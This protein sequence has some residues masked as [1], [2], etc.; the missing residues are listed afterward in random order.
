VLDKLPIDIMCLIVASFDHLHCDI[1][2]LG[3]TC[4]TLNR[5][6]ESKWLVNHEWD[7][8]KP[9]TETGMSRLRQLI[10]KNVRHIN[11]YLR[12]DEYA[13]KFIANAALLGYLDVMQWAYSVG[14]RMSCN[15]CEKAAEGGHLELLKWARENDCPWDA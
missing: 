5:H 12:I 10:S 1:C 8:S 9:C 7:I 3:L 2:R 6:W 11:C 13:G 14:C 15:T 4:K